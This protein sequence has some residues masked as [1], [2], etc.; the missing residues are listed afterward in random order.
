ML[1]SM[2]AQIDGIGSNRLTIEGVE[3]LRG[4]EARIGAD[5]M[6]VGSFIGAAVMTGGEITIQNADPQYLNMIALVYERL[7]VHW[8]T[9]GEDIF[10]PAHQS[11]R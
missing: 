5:Y 3:R 8:E 6:E 11:L 2:G 1:V 4:G 9:R 7:G 10:V